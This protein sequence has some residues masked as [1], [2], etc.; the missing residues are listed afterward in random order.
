MDGHKIPI[1]ELNQRLETNPQ[2]VRSFYPFAMFV[3][4]AAAKLSESKRSGV[5]QMSGCLRN[6]L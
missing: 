5:E 6:R 4:V 1:E 2:T 3:F